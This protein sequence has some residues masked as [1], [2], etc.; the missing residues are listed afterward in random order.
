MVR[1]EL[2]SH[3]QWLQ[4]ELCTQFVG[5]SNLRVRMVGSI[6]LLLLLFLLLLRLIILGRW[7]VPKPSWTQTSLT[8]SLAVVPTSITIPSVTAPASAS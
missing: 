2:S 6:F 7:I 8:M 1:Y 4:P 5:S 3:L